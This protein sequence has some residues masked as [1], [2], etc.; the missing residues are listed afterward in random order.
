MKTPEA[1]P[2][3]APPLYLCTIVKNE[4]E[5][6]PGLL[7]SVQGQV[8]KIVVVD[9]GSTDRTR[10][11]AQAAGA[12]ILDHVWDGDFSAARNRALDAVPVGAWVLALDAD[13]RLAP[14]GGV[15]IREFMAA[16]DYAYAALSLYNASRLDMSLDEAKAPDSGISPVLVPRLFKRDSELLWE[17]RI[18]EVPRRWTK[19]RRGVELM[20]PLL[21][22]GYAKEWI[23]KKG[24]SD[25]NR[26]ALEEEVQAH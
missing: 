2:R 9:T 22:L 21:H 20:V 10:S 8:D 23:E 19:S 4:E 24:K 1:T 18:H 14:G 15:Q 26:K 6:L 13:E 17:G 12:V 3:S 11:I 25:R 16:D 5:M 7:A